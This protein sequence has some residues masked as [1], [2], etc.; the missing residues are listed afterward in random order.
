MKLG[1]KVKDTVTGFTGIA[2]C[3]AEWLN[4][5]TR[6]SV[7]DQKLRNGNVGELQT[8]DEPQLYVVKSAAVSRGSQSTGGPAPTPQR[9][10]N[11][12]R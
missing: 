2:V 4:G 11:P 6:W 8:F 7:Q 12:T 5:C 10:P 3:K 1:D 9:S